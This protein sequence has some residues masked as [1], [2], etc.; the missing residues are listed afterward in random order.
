MGEEL[1]DMQP[2][3]ASGLVD[4]LLKE[5]QFTEMRELEEQLRIVN[6]EKQDLVQQLSKKSEAT[7]G[8]ATIPSNGHRSYSVDYSDPEEGDE[9]TMNNKSNELLELKETNKQLCS[10]ETVYQME[11]KRLSEEIDELKELQKDV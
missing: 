8:E 9:Y 5:L 2:A 1:K 11:I 4:D 10:R 7:Q 3:P 6:Q